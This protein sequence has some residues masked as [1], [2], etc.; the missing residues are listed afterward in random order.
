MNKIN[1]RYYL[2]VYAIRQAIPIFSIPIF[3]R[4]LSVEQ[5]GIYALS[6]FFGTF[7]SGISNFGLLTIFQRNF[8]EYDDKSDVKDLLFS[9]IVFISFFLISILVIINFLGKP[10][11]ELL[12]QKKLGL[13][14]LTLSS[15]Q[16]GIKSLNQLFYS[17]YKN[18][19]NGKLYSLISIIESIL[20][21]I[22]PLSLLIFLKK[23]VELY[24]IGFLTSNLI[25]FIIFYS[26][27]FKL[28]IPQFN[29]YELKKSLKL[30]LPLTPTIFFGII[31]T[32]FDR[33]MLGIL[34]NLAGT[35]LY[36]IGQKIANTSFS[37][38]TSLQNIFEPEVYK[39]MFSND[40]NQI[41]QISNYLLPY[42]FLSS[43][44]CFGLILFSNELVFFFLPD[45]YEK[46]SSIISILSFTYL[47][48]FF[49]KIPQ[50]LFKKKT[51]LITILSMISI[52]TNIILNLYFISEFGI[53]GAA[54]ATA[55]AG[56]LSTLLR[57][58]FGQKY[59]FINWDWKYLGIIIIAI[60][61]TSF[62]ILIFDLYYLKFWNT[63]LKII[64]LSI[65][66]FFGFRVFKIRKVF[67]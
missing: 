19:L 34:N 24:V 38:I 4:I 53:I 6:I 3:T 56:S 45:E 60:L 17:F 28:K 50:L 67:F 33:Y 21:L 7:I 39:K 25:V 42:F 8:F 58:Y 22:I 49:G 61:I 27:T 18:S 10:I 29:T 5:F 64:F 59:F 63:I 36:D 11:I 57:F 62:K 35:G 15:L 52:L 2:S 1:F 51:V 32:Q 26:K 23:S 31:N 54:Y 43:V 30:S 37:F 46:S 14:I 48:Y 44:F 16:M 66:I 47:I 20:M 41:N 55:I 9:M 13:G 40:I 12:F 65:Y